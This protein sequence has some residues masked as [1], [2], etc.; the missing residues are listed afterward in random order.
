MCNFHLIPRPSHRFWSQEATSETA[1]DSVAQHLGSEAAQIRKDSL[2]SQRP[3]GNPSR[4]KDGLVWK[5]GNVV[6]A[7]INH[8]PNH[9][10]WQTPFPNGWF[11]IVLTTLYSSS[12]HLNR[13]W[14]WCIGIGT[15]PNFQ[16]NP[17]WTFSQFS[18]GLH[19][20]PLLLDMLF[21]QTNPIRNPKR[22]PFHAMPL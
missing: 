9:Y 4:F 3:T 14:K 13:D 10:K 11:M 15:R 18:L 19:I 12:G 17:D 2:W 21:R 1:R 6:E 16:T 7:I 20:L 5:K 22:G 8:P